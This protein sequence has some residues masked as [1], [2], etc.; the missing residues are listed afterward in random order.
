MI[1]HSRPSDRRAQMPFA[2]IAVLLVIVGGSSLT[3]IGLIE[4]SSGSAEAAGEDLEKMQQA[5]ATVQSL[6]EDGAMSILADVS[7]RSA[8]GGLEDVQLA[9]QEGLDLWMEHYFPLR[10]GAYTVDILEQELVL[11]IRHLSLLDGD[12]YSRSLPLYPVVA[13]SYRVQVSSEKGGME[14][15]LDMDRCGIS[16]LPF[17]MDRME[18]MAM[19]MEGSR[20]TFTQLLSHQLSVL[21]QNRALR[22]YGIDSID[23]EKGSAALLTE[24]DVHTAIDN[25][26]AVLEAI[27][28]RSVDSQDPVLSGLA[29]QQQVDPAALLLQ[30]EWDGSLDLS[31][32]MA[33]TLASLTDRLI[34]QWLDYLHIVDVVNIYEAMNDG[35]V[36]FLEGM[37]N[38]IVGSQGSAAV[39]YVK[40]RMQEAGYSEWSYGR[41]YNGQNNLVINL[42][43][44]QGGMQ[45]G[46]WSHIMNLPGAVLVD[47]IPS[48]DVFQWPGWKSF[49][50]QYRQQTNEL[51][52]YLR[53][54]LMGI[55]DAVAK[56]YGLGSIDVG[57]EPFSGQSAGD[58]ILGAVRQALM[59]DREWMSRVVSHAIDAARTLDQLG[60]AMAAYVEENWMSMY[61]VWDSFSSAVIPVESYYRQAM[62]SSYGHLY[63]FTDQQWQEQLLYML[64]SNG[65]YDLIF[66]QIRGD[67][68]WRKDNMVKVLSTAEGSSNPLQKA[69]SQVARWGVDTL[70]GLDSLI[71]QQMERLL[72][73]I[74][75]SQSLQGGEAVMD[76]P[77]TSHYVLYD[78]DGRAFLQSLVVQRN[79]DLHVKV[80]GFAGRD[81]NT[82]H[83]GFEALSF[84]PYSSVME[85][86]VV[87]S[88]T[89]TLYSLNDAM[90][91][92]SMPSNHSHES[93]LSTKLQIPILSAWPM[94][95]VDYRP[96]STLGGDMAKILMTV[97]GPL[98]S[99]L[100]QAFQAADGVFA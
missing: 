21:A 83:T 28:F 32:V 45:Y 51:V 49:N 27:N 66:T 36:N 89:H 6:L 17:L 72:S 15:S 5:F 74:G 75:S 52:Q 88:V 1:P 61:R 34:L 70:P 63:S 54:F 19:D 67:A 43:A 57:L 85:V 82:H 9:F 71:M 47:T 98:L 100:T 95:G 22:G 90:S 93:V 84:S 86:E 10:V 30:R 58:A 38:E 48:V 11:D 12:D 96:T 23:G 56:T 2:M 76:L 7:S 18:G 80:L 50:A 42:P 81:R 78:P 41:M 31:S 4:D 16:P 35:V 65:V 91:I 87:G 3:I 94:M 26:L 92:W 77:G 37:F 60:E 29:E 33:Q 97:A 64:Q 14:R 99:P 24:A 40:Q 25:A 69:I 53:S 20:S 8:V 68:E 39:S 46:N 79:D 55:C 73:G 62:M 44:L 13:G 59:E